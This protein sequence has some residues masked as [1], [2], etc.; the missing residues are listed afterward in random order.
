VPALNSQTATLVESFRGYKQRGDTGALSALLNHGHPADIADLIDQLEEGEKIEAFQVLDPAHA[1]EVVFELNN[2]AREVILD[3][4]EDERIVDLL[5][6]LESDDAA[7]LVR[8]LDQQTQAGV[9]RLFGQEDAEAA[10]DVQRLLQFD[11]NTAGAM[12]Q[13]ELVRVHQ[14]DTA[15]DAIESCRRKRED[16]DHIY[17][18]YVTG[19]GGK[20][21]GRIPLDKLLFADAGATAATLMEASPPAINAQLSRDEVAQW[22]R[23]EGVPVAPVVDDTGILVGRITSDD[24]VSILEEERGKDF[25]R[26]L[27]AGEDEEVFDPP[28]RA[29][30]RRLPWLFTYLALGLITARIIATFEPTIAKFAVLA[31]F[32]PMVGGFGG[33]AATQTLGVI[34]RGLATGDLNLRLAGKALSKEV[35]VGLFEGLFVGL[36]VGFVVGISERKPVLGIVLGVALFLAASVACFAATLVPLFLRALRVDPALASGVIVTTFTDMFG[37]ATFLGLATLLAGYM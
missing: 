29:I 37:F 16:L 17:D 32:M 19:E 3:N 27:G 14:K 11:D 5:D 25:L 36:T 4:I 30:Q 18:I 35:M 7:E 20:L 10:E 1:A 31:S 6:E 12:M 24:V 15:A 22:F 34:V 26:M 13:V 21:K 33:S 23:R 2:H 28:L 9:L 8:E